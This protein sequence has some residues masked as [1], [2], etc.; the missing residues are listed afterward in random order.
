MLDVDL[1]VIRI[2]IYDQIK[3]Y[4]NN[5]KKKSI[6]IINHL[7]NN[8]KRKQM[9]SIS[10]MNSSIDLTLAVFLSDIRN[11][12]YLKLITNFNDLKLN[13][14][15]KLEIDEI[16]IL[17]YKEYEEKIIRKFEYYIRY[18]PSL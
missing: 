17:K 15:L 12:I 2:G 1:Y 9:I 5:F 4:I 14:I 16:L 11:K 13:G 6:N 8:N 18:N 7:Y 10:C 3:D